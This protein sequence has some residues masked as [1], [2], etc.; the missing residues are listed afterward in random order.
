MLR[1]PS[2]PRLI[3]SDTTLAAMSLDNVRIVLVEPKHHGNI[4]AVA[5]AMK[6]MDLHRLYLVRPENFPAIDAERRALGAVDILINA[7]EVENL[8]DAVADCRLAIGGTSR[9]RSYAHPILDARGAGRKLFSEASSGVEVAAVFGTERTGLTND[10]LNLCQ[11]EL[12]IPTSREFRSL[13]LGSAVQLLAYEI[14]MAS[15]DGPP[16]HERDVDYPDIATLEYFYKHLEEVLDARGFITGDK[17]EVAL[18]KLRRLF[19]RS[20]PE[21]GELKMLHSLVNLMDREDEK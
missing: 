5:R 11:Y 14:Y 17:R 3:F 21:V 13:N 20:R 4:G 2:P 10:D 16:T 9:A 19:A 1:A 7:V 15:L 8:A 12:R 6:T 18:F